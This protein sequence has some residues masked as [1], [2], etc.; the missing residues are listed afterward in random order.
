[1]VQYCPIHFTQYHHEFFNVMVNSPY[2]EYLVG[3]IL[4]E[5]AQ[6]HCTADV[7]KHISKLYSDKYKN[8]IY[9]ERMIIRGYKS[10][11]SR[12]KLGYLFS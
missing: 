5:Y 11:W 3:P 9:M 2:K 8:A 6:Y 7:R 4:T 1:M 12:L 10:Q